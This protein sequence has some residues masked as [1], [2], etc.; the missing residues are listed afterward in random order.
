[1]CKARTYKLF[2]NMLKCNM[3]NCT[4][5]RANNLSIDRFVNLLIGHAT[6][7]PKIKLL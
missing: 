3:Y 7:L 5:K 4:D 2:E 6:Y 1:M